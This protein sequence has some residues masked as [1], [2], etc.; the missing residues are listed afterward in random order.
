[1]ERSLGHQ[2]GIL[3]DEEAKVGGKMVQGHGEGQLKINA[4]KT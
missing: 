3:I 2:A 1:M 4:C